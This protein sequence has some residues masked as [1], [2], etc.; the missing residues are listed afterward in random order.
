MPVDDYDDR[1]A[2]AEYG[3][4]DKTF[5]DTNIVVLV[6]F[7]LCCRGLAFILGLVCY[8]TAKDPKAKS[9]AL[10]VVLIDGILTALGVVAQL[11][12]A[13]AGLL[14]GGGAR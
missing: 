2:R 8:L 12:G 3:P 6:L 11:T 5:R 1:P 4:L 7:A 10:V 9:N 14:A 13:L